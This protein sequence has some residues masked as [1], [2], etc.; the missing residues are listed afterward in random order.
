L[1]IDSRRE[2]SYADRFS[3]FSGGNQQEVVLA[4]WLL[5]EPDVLLLEEPTRGIDV[6]A[7]VDVYRL[8]LDTAKAGKAVLVVSSDSAELLGICERIIVMFKG[9]VA[10]ELS[11]DEADEETIA[12]YSVERRD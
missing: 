1:A 9:Q 7:K 8:I 11:A 5:L 4:R 6:N 10:K 3:G 2:I 12:Y